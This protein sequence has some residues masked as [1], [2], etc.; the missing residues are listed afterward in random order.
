MN[1]CKI[2]KAHGEIVAWNFTTDPV[3]IPINSCVYVVYNAIMITWTKSEMKS[4]EC[5]A[6]S[7]S[8]RHT[9]KRTFA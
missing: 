3:I 1:V 4:S 6:S 5:G 7:T 8:L 2:V 9:I